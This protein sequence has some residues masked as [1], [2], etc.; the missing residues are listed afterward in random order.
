MITMK[1]PRQNGPVQFEGKLLYRQGPSPRETGVFLLSEQ[2]ELEVLAATLEARIPLGE[3]ERAP[4]GLYAKITGHRDGRTIAATA[5]ETVIAPRDPHTPLLGLALVALY[6]TA[7]QL[8]A[9]T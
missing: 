2:G 5:I 1:A 8:L 9:T 7:T 3:V 4:S 6:E